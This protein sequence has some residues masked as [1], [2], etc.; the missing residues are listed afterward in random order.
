MFGARIDEHCDGALF[1][2]VKAPTLQRESVVREIEYR[3]R[4]CE[5]APEPSLHVLFIVGANASQVAR[6]QRVHMRIDNFLGKFGLIVVGAKRGTHSPSRDCEKKEC[7]RR[8]QPVPKEWL[9]HRGRGR[10]WVKIGTDLFP[11][12]G[13]GRLIEL[14]DLQS[15]T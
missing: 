13:R 8:G 7:S 9:G 2:N 4:K 5:L 10:D 1:H 14:R 3:E 12:R 6:L 15:P 11:K